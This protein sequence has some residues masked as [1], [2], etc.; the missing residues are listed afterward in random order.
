MDII[1]F[2]E[3]ITFTPLYKEKGLWI[4]GATVNSGVTVQLRVVSKNKALFLRDME[5]VLIFGTPMQE[6]EKIQYFGGSFSVNKVLTVHNET[7]NERLYVHKWE[8]Y[9]VTVQ[10]DPNVINMHVPDD[11]CAL[12]EIISK[13]SFTIKKLRTCL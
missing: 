2:W 12:G 4:H 1:S 9:S 8:P 10:L 13:P 6:K 3:G 11:S 5:W 7:E